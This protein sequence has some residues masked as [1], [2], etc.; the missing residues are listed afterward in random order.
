MHSLD[1]MLL[2]RRSPLGAL[3]LQDKGTVFAVIAGYLTTLVI[4][5][6]VFRRFSKD[7]SDYFRA[8]GKAAWWLIGG[9][10]FMRGF[11]AWTF[12]GAAGAAFQAGWSLPMMFGANV[13][14]FLTVAAVSGAW[15][16]QLRC[17][18]SIDM[19]RLRFGPGLEQFA[20]Y[21][22]MLTGPIYG[23]IQLYGLAIFTSILLETNMYYTIILLGLVVR[24]Y[25]GIS[26]AWA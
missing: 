24:F 4:V 5:G 15:F 3:A 10:V 21:L 18:T 25:A 16:R 8:G 14:A 17:I 7:T 12:T 23:G 19:I 20:A 9:S 2:L 11:S 1:P 6:L 13:M 22:G 26:G